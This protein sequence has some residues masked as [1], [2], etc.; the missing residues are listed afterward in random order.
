MSEQKEMLADAVN[1]LF[2]D[3]GDGAAAGMQGW[4]T[5]LWQQVEALGLPLV[6]VPEAAGGVGGD[7]EDVC[8]ILYSVGRHA[9]P[10]PVGEAML[11]AQ[12][13]ASAG[14]T[15]AEGPTTLAPGNGRLVRQNG[16]YRFSGDLARVPWGRDAVTVVT[17]ADF[18]GATQVV[19]LPVASARISRSENCAGEPRDT[20]SFDGAEVQAA[21]STATEARALFD[22]AALLRVAQSVGALEGALHR[23]VEY[24]KER[25]QFGRAIGQFQAVQQQLALFGAEVAAVSCAAR[26]ACRAAA[27]T[28]EAAFA[29]GAAKLRTNLAIGLATATAH[30]VHAAIGFTHEYGLRHHTQRLWA[31]RSEFG[32]DRYW[33]ERLGAAIAARGAAH[34]WT[35]LTAR[36]DAAAQAV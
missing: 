10:L 8:E 21:P 36:D 17:T 23:S 6:L 1:R 33:S 30:Q 4:Q 2:R 25:K 22:Y 13:A 12:L 31:W 24:A 5:A 18:E 34:F 14:L 32:N 35:D 26:A 28:G 20:L 9:I 15:L 29:I 16:G 11:A 27:V 19:L 3:A 7:W